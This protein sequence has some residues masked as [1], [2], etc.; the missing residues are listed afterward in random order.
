MFSQLKSSVIQEWLKLVKGSFDVRDIWNEIGIES[1]EN[2][3]HLRVIL[4]RLEEKGMVVSLGGGK[5][6]K[7]D[8]EAKPID[9]QSA[10]PKNVVPLVFPFGIEE[11][12][13]IYPK[14]VVIVAGGKNQGKT[15]FLYNF[16]KMNMEDFVID[17]YN[18]ETGPE[19]MNER[20]TSLDIPNPAPFNTFE[21]YDNFADVIHPDHISIIDYLDMNSEVYLVGTEIDAMFRKL[22]KGVA[23]IGLQ[24][25]PPAVTFIRGEK[26]LVERDLAYGG[27]FTAKRACLYISLSANRCKLVVVK[28]PAKPRVNPV[29]LAWT[30]GWAEDG[31]HFTDIQ[32]AY[33]D[34][35]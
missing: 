9:W 23:I 3:Q 8:T 22:N 26:K 30:F 13:K 6:K 15:G 35:F 32:R 1:P 4:F 14:S 33:G 28:T 25:P 12:A 34:E 31:S 2:R 27:G 7:V 17:L 20:F 5:Y 18:S 24:K 21:R 19:Q 16:I 29:N 10:N 11:W